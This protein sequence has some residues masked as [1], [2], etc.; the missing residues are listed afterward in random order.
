MLEKVESTLIIYENAK[1]AASRLRATVRTD[2]PVIDIDMQANET[3]T[4]FRMGRSD[5]VEFL[6]FVSE[7]LNDAPAW[8]ASSKPTA[9][10]V[11]ERLSDD[12]VP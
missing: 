2:S 1:A 3:S 11:K 5:L 8:D 6:G 9:K 12:H 10:P 7:V 4:S